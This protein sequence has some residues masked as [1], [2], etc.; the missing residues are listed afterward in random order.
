MGASYQEMLDT[1][2]SVIFK[3]LEMIS[4]ENTYSKPIEQTKRKAK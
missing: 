1:P 4:M 3:D 2:V